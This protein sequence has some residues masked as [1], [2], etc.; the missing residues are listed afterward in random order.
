MDN[1][2]PIILTLNEESRIKDVIEMV[3]PYFRHI[4]VVDGGSKDDTVKIAKKHNA[5]VIVIKG[6]NLSKVRNEA[7]FIIREKIPS[8]KYFLHIDADEKWSTYFFKSLPIILTK[9]AYNFI[10]SESPE[11]DTLVFTFPRINMPDKKKYPDHQTRMKKNIPDLY[12]KHFPNEAIYYR[13]NEGE[14]KLANQINCIILEEFPI[15]HLERRKDI[16]REWW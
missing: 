15:I 4:Y 2:V 8:C 13:N 9:Y 12:W 10:Y 7:E 14:E 11:N 6:K 16:N 5:T 3:M 1:V